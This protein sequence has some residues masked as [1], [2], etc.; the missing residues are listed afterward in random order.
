MPSLSKGL[1]EFAKAK[2]IVSG[3]DFSPDGKRFATLSTDRKVRVFNFLSGKLLRIFDET[4]AR[5]SDSQH[6]NQAIPNMEFGRR[7]IHRY[8]LF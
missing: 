6:S 3:L 8:F 4:L 5:Y 2:T 7:Y 1:Y